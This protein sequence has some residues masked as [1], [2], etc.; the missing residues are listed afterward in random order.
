[1]KIMMKKCYKTVNAL[2][3][4][5]HG[6]LSIYEKNLG[7]LLRNLLTIVVENYTE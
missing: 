2:E 5:I 1:M 3:K 7:L 6:R 4:K